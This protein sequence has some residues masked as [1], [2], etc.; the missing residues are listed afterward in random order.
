[1]L[2]ILKIFF[3][4]KGTRPVAVLVCLLLGGIA[5]GLGLSILLPVMSIV[6]GGEDGEGSSVLAELESQWG[7]ET[8]VH[9]RD[10]EPGPLTTPG[11]TARYQI[12]EEIASGSQ[13]VVYRSF[14]DTHFLAG[15]F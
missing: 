13:G 14:T 8:R 9:L 4:A 15:I 7:P 10:R 5:E 12:L 3:Q 1:M 11:T 6:L 2:E